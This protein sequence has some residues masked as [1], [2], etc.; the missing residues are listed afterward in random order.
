MDMQMVNEGPVTMNF[1]DFE[2]AMEELEIAMESLEVAR[3]N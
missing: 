3:E 2:L 1:E